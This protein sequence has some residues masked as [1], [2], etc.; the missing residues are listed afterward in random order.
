MLC[1]IRH[2]LVFNYCLTHVCVQGWKCRLLISQDF[3]SLVVQKPDLDSVFDNEKHN[4]TGIKIRQNTQLRVIFVKLDLHTMLMSA[5]CI[6]S[7]TVLLLEGREE[8]IGR[9]R[10]THSG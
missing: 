5:H 9:E 2:Y 6:Y 7:L 4:N 1:F 10:A 8:G 3:L